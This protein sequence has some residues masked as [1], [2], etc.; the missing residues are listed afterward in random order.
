MKKYLP[1]ILITIAVL[2]VVGFVIK[3]LSTP[4]SELNK[5]D[6]TSK[7]L[8][9]EDQAQLRTGN[10][11]GNKDSKVVV[12]EFGDYQCPAC[13]AW[14]PFL[15]DTVLPAYQDRILFVF[16]NFPLPIHKNAQ[17]A[18]QAAEAAVLQG[19]FW[20]MHDKLYEKQKE[21]ENESNPNG[22]FEAYA[23]EIGLDIDKYKSDFSSN[24]VKDVI[25]NDV[26]LGEKIGIP[27][28]PTFLVNG[29]V[30]KTSAESDLTT[31][32]EQALSANQ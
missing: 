25:K 31:A 14:H 22:K 26:A 2:V 20:P 7:T 28:T 5:Q 11:L 3:A 27:G 6:N 24:V 30:I 19:K 1:T 8:S 16:K 15:K 13:A 9:E 18:S 32:I 17:A 29:V 23:R 12:T 4:D 21:W 10:T